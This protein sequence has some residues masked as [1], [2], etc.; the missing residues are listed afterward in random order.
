MSDQDKVYK[1]AACYVIVSKQP[2]RNGE[3][4]SELELIASVGRIETDAQGNTQYVNAYHCDDIPHLINALQQ[5]D[6]YMLLEKK[7]MKKC[8]EK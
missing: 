6:R 5:A 3:D 4:S 2:E 1:V 8:H 7:K